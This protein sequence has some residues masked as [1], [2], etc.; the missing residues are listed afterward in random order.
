MLARE[1]YLERM[2]PLVDIVSKKKH[3]FCSD[4]RSLTENYRNETD[5]LK[6]NI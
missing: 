2:V 1:G 4:Q 6:A 3:S 5:Q